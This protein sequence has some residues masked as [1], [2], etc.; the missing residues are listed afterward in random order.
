MNEVFRKSIIAYLLI[1]LLY[2]NYTLS[3]KAYKKVQG[4]TYIKNNNLENSNFKSKELIQN[5]IQNNNGN[6]ISVK[7]KNY[8]NNNNNNKIENEKIKYEVD[9]AD[10]LSEIIF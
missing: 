7:K 10:A 2:T 9:K 1:I 8:N 5:T 6:F 4:N 3:I